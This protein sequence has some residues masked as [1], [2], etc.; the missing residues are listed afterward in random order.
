VQ[1]ALLLHVVVGQGAAV[2]KLLSREDEALLVGRDANLGTDGV[3][4]VR[5]LDFKS[6]GLASR[7]PA[8]RY[9]VARQ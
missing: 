1:R 2:L 3:A 8:A 4:G 5:G 7:G 6:D 9:Q